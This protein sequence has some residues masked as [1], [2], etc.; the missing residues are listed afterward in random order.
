MTIKTILNFLYMKEY[1]NLH[2]IIFP[3]THLKCQI[4][5]VFI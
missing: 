1:L 2:G 4:T 3:H 5:H